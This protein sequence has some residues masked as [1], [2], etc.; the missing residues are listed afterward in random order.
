M[1][2]PADGAIVM[3][4]GLVAGMTLSMGGT[5]GADA[6]QVPVSNLG[7][8][9][10]LPP[11]DFVGSAELVAEL[12][13]AD[14][15]IAHRRTIH[16]EWMPPTAPAQHKLDR[17]E[18]AVL[19]KR[20]KELLA[21]GDLAAARLMLLPAAKANDAEAALALAATYDPFALRELTVHGFSSDAAMARTW[22]E[23]AREFGS[24]EAAQRLDVLAKGA[25]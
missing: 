6:W 20:G 24:P 3:I 14:N 13:L 16:L 7:N 17:E 9:W 19:L 10:I 23:K 22:Y 21:N 1:E 5:V 18:I 4:T 12:R 15:T 8:T 11:K 2:G 25:R